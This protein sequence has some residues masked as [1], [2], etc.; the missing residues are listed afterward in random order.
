MSII[1]KIACERWGHRWDGMA[2]EL[3]T[4]CGASLNVCDNCA[5]VGQYSKAELRLVND[6]SGG[7]VCRDCWDTF[8]GDRDNPAWETA[9]PL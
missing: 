2:A 5:T 7:K 3:C 1:D 8:G 9:E 6:P 4:T